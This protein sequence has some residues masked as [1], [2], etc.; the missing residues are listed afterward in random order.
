MN[1]IWSIILSYRSFIA[2]AWSATYEQKG[3]KKQKKTEEKEEKLKVK[4]K[5][6]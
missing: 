1:E 5:K 6:T 2:T 3:K 4:M